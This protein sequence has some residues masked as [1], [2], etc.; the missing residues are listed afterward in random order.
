MNGFGVRGI[1]CR[2]AMVLALEL[3]C[4]IVRLDQTVIADSSET[5]QQGAPHPLTVE[6]LLSATYFARDTFI[7]AVSPDDEWVAYTVHAPTHGDGGLPKEGIS[8]V[9]LHRL[10]STES[11]R[12]S[13]PGI[14]S[15]GPAWSHDGQTIAFACGDEQKTAICL[16]HRREKELTVLD[17]PLL[18][19]Y[20]SGLLCWSAD[21]K[22]I[23]TLLRPEGEILA[24]VKSGESFPRVRVFRSWAYAATEK[25]SASENSDSS[26]LRKSIVDLALIDIQT[27]SVQRL[28]HERGI[29]WFAPS[30]DG[31]TVAL[32]IE[33]GRVEEDSNLRVFDIALISLETGAGSRAALGVQMLY[34]GRAVSWAPDSNVL[35]WIANGQCQTLDLTSKTV[36][37][38]TPRPIFWSNF[39]P[40]SWDQQGNIYL[41]AAGPWGDRHVATYSAT[42]YTALWKFA[43]K[44]YQGREL[45]QLPDVSLLGMVASKATHE[46]WQ[47]IGADS[48]YV[49]YRDNRNGLQGFL[50][51]DAQRGQSKRLFEVQEELAMGGTH[52]DL[53]PDGKY[54]VYA[55]RTAARPDDLWRIANYDLAHPYRITELNPGLAA[56]FMGRSQVVSWRTKKGVELRGTLLLPAGYVASKRYPLVTWVYG[57]ALGS[58]SVNN[59]GIVAASPSSSEN[60]QLLASRGIAAFFPDV[61][62]H[63]GSPMDEIS[64]EVLPGIDRVIEMGIADPDR[65]GLWGQSYGGYSVLSILV[66]SNR[67]KAAVASSGIYSLPT[68]YGFLDEEGRASYAVPYME[69]GQGRMGVSPWEDR[70]RYIR[71]SPWF[72]LN[73]VDCPLL[74]ECGVRDVS[75]CVQSDS[76]FVGLERLGKEVEFLKYEKEGHTILEPDDRVD[77]AN[78]VLAWFD[79]YLK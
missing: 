12:I 27:R 25:A 43:A 51:V 11:Y 35:A 57:G 13:K 33:R 23:L 5:E 32:T 61:P 73:E 10:K 63:V 44:T 45:L 14:A 29:A 39:S 18:E 49:V 46:I 47:P 55:A 50:E 1:T 19:S 28:F 34:T 56:F 37:Q 65:L 58:E 26:S 9:W 74:I 41:L 70:E 38:I 66:R 6:A 24:V 77:Y 7:P 4:T 79:E 20:R 31:R 67:F 52:L 78:R 40:P 59:F 22:K 64:D 8:E 3:T 71:N 2:V 53:S 72:Y 17:V 62:M 60:L 76:L 68:L 36:R 15:Y 21:D 30:P 42:G 54:V 48:V 75:A 69:R 16:W